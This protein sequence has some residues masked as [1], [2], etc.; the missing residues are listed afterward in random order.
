MSELAEND[1]LPQ[2]FDAH[3]S[4]FYEYTKLAHERFIEAGCRFA[5]YTTVDTALKILT[6]REIWMR[7]T[8]IMN[9]PNEVKYGFEGVM[10]AL[11]SVEGEALAK[12]VDKYHPN[13]MRDVVKKYV[14]WMGNHA[15]STFI[16]SLT[17]HGPDELD[18]NIR[19]NQPNN[20]SETNP[21]NNIERSFDHL[22]KLSLWRGYGGRAGVAFVVDGIPFLKRTKGLHLKSMP[23]IYA[24]KEY[25]VQLLK[26][27]RTGIHQNKGKFFIDLGFEGARDALVEA[28]QLITI[29][30]KHPAFAEER[31]WRI[32]ATRND[33]SLNFG[34]VDTVTIGEVPQQIIRVPL[35]DAE[36]YGLTGLSPNELIKLVIVGPSDYPGIARQPLLEAMR[37]AGIKQPEARLIDER[38]PLRANQR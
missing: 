32:I 23:V 17:V 22:G 3:L 24:A 21:S 8:R 31:E 25:S 9:D 30:L 1:L 13:Q 26:S 10:A 27:I 11:D 2:L 12:A 6:N 37:S 15:H 28:L 38:I 14:S 36:E 20:T 29:S 18:N 35:R 34:E 5:Y 19:R 33:A 7:D 16:T 4:T